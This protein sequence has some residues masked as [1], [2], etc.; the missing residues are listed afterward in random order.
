MSEPSVALDVRDVSAGYP[1]ERTAIDQLSFS[2]QPGE[3]VALV[4]PNGAG[5]STLFKAIAGLIPFTN[6]E[7]SVAWCRLP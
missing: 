2:V 6:G 3:R 5:K 7:I 4:G 1:G